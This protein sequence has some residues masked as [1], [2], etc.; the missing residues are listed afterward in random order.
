MARVKFIDPIL[1]LQGK[2]SQEDG[3]SFRTRYGKQHSYRFRHPYE[4]PATEAQLKTRSSFA[5][6]RK[7][8]F[9]ELKEPARYAYW[10]HL[11]DEQDRYVRLDCFV[12]A[13]LMEEQNFNMSRVKM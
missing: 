9:A 8:A 5:E 13:K 12:T 11:F 7:R 10:K 2:V 1:S 6:I 4:G 3:I